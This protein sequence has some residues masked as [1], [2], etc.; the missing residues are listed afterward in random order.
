[1]VIKYLKI[2]KLLIFIK[3]QWASSKSKNS[4]YH[5]TTNKQVRGLILFPINSRLNWTYFK[6]I[7][8]YPVETNPLHRESLV[9]LIMTFPRPLVLIFDN[10]IGSIIEFSQAFI[11]IK[12][13]ILRSVREAAL[14]SPVAKKENGNIDRHIEC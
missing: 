2:T 11:L 13:G 4:I 14:I 6:I 10:F 9:A 7:H 5:R 8:L 3:A 12:I 1:M